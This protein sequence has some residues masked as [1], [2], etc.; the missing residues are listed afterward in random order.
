MPPFS[1]TQNPIAHA[2]TIIQKRPVTSGLITRLVKAILYTFLTIMS[3]GLLVLLQLPGTFNTS[4]WTLRVS[5]TLLIVFMILVLVQHF[6]VMFHTLSITVAALERERRQ[7][8]RWDSL[9]MTGIPA[10]AIVLGKWWAM[11]RACWRDYAW[12]MLWRAGAVIFLAGQNIYTPNGFVGPSL[13]NMLIAALMVATFTMMNLLFTTA[14]AVYAGLA[15]RRAALAAAIITRIL[16]IVFFSI[17]L[18]VIVLQLTAVWYLPAYYYSTS[19]SDT[20][21]TEFIAGTSI[22][23]LSAIGSLFDNGSTLTSLVTSHQVTSYYSVS[24]QFWVLLLT[25]AISIAFYLM[26]TGLALQMAQGRAEHHGALR[27]REVKV[28]QHGLRQ[29]E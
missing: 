12:L 19:S 20:T 2:E 4:T 28:S 24:S 5:S 27:L 21:N 22:A 7:D 23:M 17:G 26:L 16:M 18:V 8:E 13:G 3:L 29:T 14:C 6:R 15:Y 11:V 9:V 1:F 25:F 10:R